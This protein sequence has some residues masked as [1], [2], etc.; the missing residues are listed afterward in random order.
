MGAKRRSYTPKYR[1]EAAHLV[2]DTGRMIA[3]VAREIGVGEQLLG[4]W[5]AI[6]RSRMDDPPPAVDADERAELERLRREVAEL[7]MD[8][9]V[10]KK[11]GSL[12]RCG[13]YAPEQAYEVVEAEKAAFPIARATELPGVS[14]SGFYEWR[15]RQ[16]APPTARER[17]REYLTEK[18][19]AAHECSGDV[20]GS[21][22]VHAE[23]RAAGEVVSQKTV[24]K[25]MHDNGIQGVSPRSWAPVTT[26]ADESPHSIPVWWVADL[27][28]VC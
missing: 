10:S 8:P 11:S 1:R 26:I 3:E 7:R 13:E 16:D 9:R 12:L 2:I 28:V 24:A 20:Y 27:I 14:R 23:L 25:I 19:V 6:E 21:P 18:I 15:E 4:R 17:R 5:V 22:R